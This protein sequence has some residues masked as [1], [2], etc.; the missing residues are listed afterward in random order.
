MSTECWPHEL[1]SGW[2]NEL[3]HVRCALCRCELDEDGTILYDPSE[4]DEEPTCSKCD[5]TRRLM[6]FKNPLRGSTMIQVPCP[7]CTKTGETK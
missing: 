6:V 5:G 3:G 7:S 2:M 4:D 1:E